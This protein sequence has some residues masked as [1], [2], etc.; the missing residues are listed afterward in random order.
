M[1]EAPVVASINYQLQPIVQFDGNNWATFRAAFTNYARQQGFFDVLG[2][3]GNEE[4]RENAERWRQR[5]AQATTALC[6][7]WV[8]DK[9]LPVFRYNAFENA[10]C[11]WRKLNN[12]YNNITDIRSLSLRDRAERFKQRQDQPIMDWIGGLNTRVSDLAASGYD[13]DDTYRKQLVRHNC[14]SMFQPIVQKI[15]LANSEE[16]TR[17]GGERGFFG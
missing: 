5:M 17:Q 3:A 9:I 4:P 6:S 7:G 15:L 8:S 1:A 12:H 13:C 2:E 10:N 11:I 16:P 14:N